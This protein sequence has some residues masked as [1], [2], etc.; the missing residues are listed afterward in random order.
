MQNSQMQFKE[1]IVEMS[2]NCNIS[3]QMCGFGFRY[4]PVKKEKFMSADN[5]CKIVDI[6]ANNTS[7]LRLNG[8]GESTIHPDFTELLNWTHKKYPLLQ[9]SIFTNAS[10]S[11][12]SIN[13]Q[14]IPTKPF[15]SITMVH[16]MAKIQT[17]TH[18]MQLV[19]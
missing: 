7:V 16:P 11:N 5:F 13:N 10:V 19:S 6:F 8:R 14:V 4:N 15:N 9:L 18:L 1:V 17:A 12:E 3:C 2:H